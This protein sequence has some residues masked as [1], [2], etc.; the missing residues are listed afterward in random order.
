MY[1]YDRR[2]TA[3][4]MDVHQKWREIVQKHAAAERHDLQAVLH[5]MVNYLRSVGYDLDVSKSELD[6]QWHG[7]DGWRLVGQLMITEREENTVKAETPEQVRKWVEEATGLYGYP[8]KIGEQ[9]T[10]RGPI[11]TWV[12]DIGDY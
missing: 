6:K 3:A 1:G 9:Q 4:S 10:P 11:S 12:V 5:E 7:S 2:K 8:K